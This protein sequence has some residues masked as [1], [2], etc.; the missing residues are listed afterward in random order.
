MLIGIYHIETCFSSIN[1]TSMNEPLDPKEIN[2]DPKTDFSEIRL[3][4]ELSGKD[5][6]ESFGIHIYKE[7]FK[8]SAAHFL[9][10][11]DGICERLHGH[12]YRVEAKIEGHLDKSAMVYDFLDVK[13]IIRRICDELDHCIIL[14]GK[15][16]AVE[17]YAGK[18]DKTEQESIFVLYK[19]RN[20]EKK[21]M[22]PASE[23][24]ILPIDNTSVE[25]FAYYIC[26]RIVSEL[27]QVLNTS[28]I[29]KLKV[30]VHE[31]LG[32]SGYY[33]KTIN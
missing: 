22:F 28:H 7:Y 29:R 12:N 6:K 16:P 26:H 30:I 24:I 1:F 19:E 25:M 14:P 8:F 10:L 15:N 33:T 11:P 32:Q 17:I 3:E 20:K 27:G 9:I 5:E 4:K 18:D 2:A 23:V 13:P 31:A 21:Y